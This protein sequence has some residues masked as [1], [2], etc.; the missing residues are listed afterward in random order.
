M[1]ELPWAIEDLG[2]ILIVDEAKSPRSKVYCVQLEHVE[3]GI[4]GMMLGEPRRTLATPITTRRL[5]GLHGLMLCT[6]AHEGVF[7]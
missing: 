1:A 5:V 7:T 6:R 3:R 4:L 2:L